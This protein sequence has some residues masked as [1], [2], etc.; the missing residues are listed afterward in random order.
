MATTSYQTQL[1]SVQSAIAEIEENGQ[2]NAIEGRSVTWADYD[3]LTKRER[4]LRM[5]AARESRGGIRVR[6]ITPVDG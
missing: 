6:G 1:E 3:A 2:S 4:R 5:L